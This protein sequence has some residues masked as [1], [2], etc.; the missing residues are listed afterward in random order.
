MDECS[1]NVNNCY[2]TSGQIPL[3]STS[4][5]LQSNHFFSQELFS[6]THSFLFH[7]SSLPLHIKSRYYYKVNMRK[8]LLIKMS[9]SPLMVEWLEEQLA[10]TLWIYYHGEHNGWPKVSVVRDARR[11]TAVTT[12]S[13]TSTPLAYVLLSIR[14]Y[15]P[16]T[17]APS[18]QS[19]VVI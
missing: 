6:F 1:L 3:A 7:L 8:L 16:A 2:C 14:Y 17:T 9:V 19:A 18:C 5:H 4:A 11:I 15:L 10:E 12:R 13:P